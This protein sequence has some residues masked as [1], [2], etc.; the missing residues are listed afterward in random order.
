MKRIFSLL[1]LLVAFN[2]SA[3][4][5]NSKLS[6]SWFNKDQDGH[7]LNVAT[8]NE[9]QTLVYWYV[10]HTDGTPMFLITVGTNSGNRTTGTTYYHTGMKFGDF[11]PDDVQQTVWGTSTV[12]FHGCNSA[13]LEYSSNDPAY[14]SGTIPMTRLTF[15][16]GIK[17]S[18]SPLHGT[19]FGAWANNGEVGYGIATLFENGD[20]AFGAGSDTSGEVGIGDWWVTGNN[21]FA[22]AATSYSVLGGW[23][24]I[25]GSGNFNEDALTATYSGSGELVATPI[26]S[27]QHSLNTSKMAGAYSIYDSNE[28]II[29]L[30]WSNRLYN[31]VKR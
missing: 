5:I 26:P 23:V 12:T 10:Y 3:I 31:P 4:E 18:D 21:S 28:A 27:F 8:L 24:D 15:V 25:S 11:N 13:T 20:M 17:C 2:A 6:G 19:Y 7:G 1:L 14:G 22:F 16:S 9:D 29:G 30:T